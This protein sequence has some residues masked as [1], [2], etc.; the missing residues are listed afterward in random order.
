MKAKMKW[1]VPRAVV[2]SFIPVLFPVLLQLHVEEAVKGE[3]SGLH[4][5]SILMIRNVIFKA[6]KVNIIYL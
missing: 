4:F 6:Q 2:D 1:I 3:C 5:L